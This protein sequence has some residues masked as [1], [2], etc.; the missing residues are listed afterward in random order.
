[1]LKIHPCF[2]LGILAFILLPLCSTAQVKRALMKDSRRELASLRVEDYKI[3]S[4]VIATFEGNAGAVAQEVERL[5][6]E[7]RFRNDTIGYLRANVPIAHVQELMA[8]AG[9]EAVMINT[10]H[11][12]QADEGNRSERSGLNPFASHSQVKT[13]G[14]TIK[15]DTIDTPWP[16]VIGSYPLDNPYHPWGDLDAVGFLEKNPTF[17][18][19]GVV[20]GHVEGFSDLALPEMRWSLDIN[21]NKVNKVIDQINA[22]DPL[23][24]RLS[25]E[26]GV[27]FTSN[28]KTRD[29]RWVDMQK[30]VVAE[31][32]KIIF[33]DSIY[34]APKEGNYRMGRLQLKPFLKALLVE[35]NVEID[36]T[37]QMG[38]LWEENSGKVWVDTNSNRDFSDETVL[39]DYK[40]NQKVGFWGK[41]DPATALRESVAF[42]IQLD[43]KNKFISINDCTGSHATMVVGSA[44]AND[45]FGGKIKGAA[46]NAQLITIS[47]GHTKSSYLEALMLAFKDKRIDMVLIE[48]NFNYFSGKNYLRDGSSVIDIIQER[49]LTTYPKPCVVTGD[50]TVGLAQIADH[51]V[52]KNTVAIGGYQSGEAILTNFAITGAPIDDVYSF[53]AY[54]PGGNGSLKPD[55]LSPSSIISLENGFR[56]YKERDSRILK[57]LYRLPPGYTLGGGTSQ[58]TPVAA[59]AISLLISG[60]KQKG[61]P[62]NAQKIIRALKSSARYIPVLEAHQQGNGLIQVGS[63]W[64]TL[65]NLPEAAPIQIEVEAAVKTVD[66][67]LY[68]TPHKGVG[69]FENEGWEI[70][71]KGER[72]INLTRTSGVEEPMAFDVCWKGNDGTFRSKVKVLLPLN[73]T[74]SFAVQIDAKDYGVHSAILIFDAPNHYGQECELMT[75]IVVPETFDGA[76]N[77]AIEKKEM[78]NRPNG[79]LSYFVAVPEGTSHLT[80]EIH[81]KNRDLLMYF[82]PPDK[83]VTYS[84]ASIY[85]DS[86]YERLNLSHPI[87][88]NWEVVIQEFPY[89]GYPGI[90]ENLG[91]PLPD[92]E[93]TTKLHL[94][95]ASLNEAPLNFSLNNTNHRNRSLSFTNRAAAFKGRILGAPNGAKREVTKSIREKEQHI[96]EIPID[97]GTNGLLIDLKVKGASKADLDIIVIDPE[98]QD[99]IRG[100]WYTGGYKFSG[101]GNS[102]SGKE[103]ISID[104]PSVGTWK[105]VVDGFDIPEGEVAYTYSDVV[106]HPKYGSISTTDFVSKRENNETWAV[107]THLWINEKPDAGRKATGVLRLERTTD[108]PKKDPV[109]LKRWVVPVEE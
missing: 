31:G 68:A 48:G 87:P 30:K 81:S 91:N 53:S 9:I 64:E 89:F 82:H 108:D 73:E 6:G 104:K 45:A 47:Y 40:I 103:S 83:S 59:G 98:G 70:G 107:D 90:L 46:P 34:Q 60:L 63:A 72:N 50:N 17:D 71:M 1:M 32:G 24:N 61:M 88:G 28:Y 27:G 4:L 101:Y 43:K 75:T 106:Q 33:N 8:F 78:L 97:S 84:K 35:I 94:Y 105:V 2:M 11:N 14:N 29:L 95:N 51:A 12:G 39:E 22:S 38:V 3:I 19:R 57:S 37:A 26:A 79:R 102:Y 85:D 42:T 5:G 18:G 93:V 23:D 92:V 25:E 65:Q 96:Y 80:T 76:N 36:S 13:L 20:I 54:G 99:P 100:G 10:G 66:S 56:V 58:A 49:L 62:V 15:K 55:F 41:D 52:S 21:G 86:D 16:P 44:V 74:V 77:Y 69:L 7:V 67:H 109:L